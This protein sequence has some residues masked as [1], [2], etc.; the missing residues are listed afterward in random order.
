MTTHVLI[1]DE[2]TFNVHLQYLFAGTGAKDKDVD[3]NNTSSTSL[4]AGKKSAGEN[5]LVG[6]MADGSR[7]RKG[8]FIVFYVQATH[9]DGKFYG[10]FQAKEDGIGIERYTP[11]AHPAQ[12]LLSELGK[13]LTFRFKV[14]PYKVYPEGV[15]E[16]EALDEIKHICSPQQMLWSLIYRKLRGNRG[17]TMITIYEA[18][19]LFDLI[20][21]KNN[22]TQLNIPK[23]TSLEFQGEKIIVTNTPQQKYTGTLD[24]V[25]LLPRMFYKYKNKLAHEAHLQQYITQNIGLGNNSSLDKALGITNSQIEWI[26][27]EVACGVGMQ[28]IDVM[29]SMEKSKDERILMPIELKAVPVTDTTVNQLYR[30][31]DWIEQYYIPNRPSTIQP[32]LICKAKDNSGTVSNAINSSFNTFNKNGKG[33]YLNLR[34]I[35][36]IFDNTGNIVFF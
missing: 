27:N 30:Y 35:Q 34:F 10:I 17:N 2:R 12:Y 20:R 32:V 11:P 25:N 18:D 23:N 14:S 15:T 9:S 26:G 16:W 1:V 29:I 24:K 19:R 36:Y 22:N 7:V 28:R 13:N 5:S 3:F 8:D 33:R 31:I 4:Y 21:K 6:M